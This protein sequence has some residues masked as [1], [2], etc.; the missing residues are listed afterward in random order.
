[1][2]A[3]EARGELRKIASTRLR[4]VKDWRLRHSSW[5]GAMC[6]GALRPND[7][8]VLA[9][10]SLSSVFTIALMATLTA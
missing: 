8:R 1:M 3:A 4:R 6:A 2:D 10:L 9:S 7:K 5:T